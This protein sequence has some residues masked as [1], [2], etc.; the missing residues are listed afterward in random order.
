MDLA[1][2]S[3]RIAAQLEKIRQIQQQYRHATNCGTRSDG[4]DA[5]V[6]DDGL[7]DHQIEDMTDDTHNDTCDHVDEES[8]GVGS[9]KCG[10]AHSDG[11]SWSGNGHCM[12]DTESD[13][14]SRTSDSAS[15]VSDSGCGDIE[16]DMIEDR[17]YSDYL[18]DIQEEYR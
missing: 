18:K 15:E 5:D 11:P 16:M 8:E 13:D 3:T 7:S 2:T 14:E 1:F 9:R 17:V 4:Y 6:S 10:D 12:S